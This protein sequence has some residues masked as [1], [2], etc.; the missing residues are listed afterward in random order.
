[1]S[2]FRIVSMDGGGIKGILTARIFERIDEV[3]PGYLENVDLFAGTSTGGLLAVGLASGMTPTD[4][5]KLYQTCADSVFADS[6]LD[7]LKDLGNLIGAEYSYEPL[8]KVLASQFG[9]MKLRDLP[10]KVLISSFMLDNEGKSANG[11]RSWKMKF[12]QN[13]PGP[14]SDGDQLVVDVAVRTAVAPSYFPVYQGYIDGGVAASSPAMCALAQALGRKT[15]KQQLENV[16]LLSMGTGFNPHYLPVRDA[17][18]GLVQWAPHLINIMLEGD[19]GLVDYQC[20]QMLEDCYLRLDP[21]L[22]VPVGL[23][24]TKYIPQLLETAN[25]ANLEEAISWLKHNF[26]KDEE[27]SK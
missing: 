12:F 22:P 9:S 5:R 2:R 27:R 21:P 18:W 8:K 14:E 17:D 20:R 1:M 26:I 10:K 25:Q 15:G 24:S 13:F 11:V 3:L 6:L 7:N 23:G 19:I 4:L 16:R